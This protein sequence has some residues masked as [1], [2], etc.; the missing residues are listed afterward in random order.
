MKKTYNL[1]VAVLIS[2]SLLAATN[3]SR[4]YAAE[5]YARENIAGADFNCSLIYDES[6]ACAS[7]SFVG[8]TGTVKATARGYY[9]NED[10]CE[11]RISCSGS[12][13]VPGGVSATVN[14]DDG[15]SFFAVEGEYKLASPR[16]KGDTSLYAV[17]EW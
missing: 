2:I 10:Y 6:Y 7:A 9:Y 13:T 8:Y 15:Y 16:G 5:A 3:E 4:C 1:M 11:V 12:K 14:C 17:L